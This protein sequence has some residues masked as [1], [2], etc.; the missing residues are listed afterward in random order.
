MPSKVI[1]GS[2]IR[3]C[4]RL[5]P[6]RDRIRPVSLISSTPPLCQSQQG[7]PQHE[8]VDQREGHVE[9]LRVLGDAAVADFAEPKDAFQNPKGMLDISA[10]ARFVA[11]LRCSTGSRALC[12]VAT[13]GEVLRMWRR[14]RMASRWPW[15]AVA[16]HAVSLPCNI[17]GSS[18]Y[19]GRW[20]LLPP[21]SGPA[22]PA[23][24]A[25]M[26]LHAKVPLITFLGLMHLRVTL[27]VLVLGRTRRA[28]IVA[29]MMV[30]V[31]TLIPW[32]ERCV[33]TVLNIFSPRPWASIRWRNLQIVV[34]SGA[35]S[36]P[37]SISTKPRIARSHTVLLPRRVD[38][39]NQT[40]RK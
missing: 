29:S 1:A 19:H 23:V 32:A 13:I 7:S 21:P 37:R 40:C 28:M 39:L 22:L 34:S 4:G 27:A 9:P 24:H 26:R 31:P 14:A 3:N 35:G 18:C 10:Y 15:Y 16:P 30:P 38:R 8:Q 36:R 2:A 6:Y 20:P 17:A 12:A 33:L 25:D 11:V 5:R